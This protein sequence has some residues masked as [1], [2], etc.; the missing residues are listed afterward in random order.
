MT[1][2]L[3]LELWYNALHDPQGWKLTT[4]DPQ[5]MKALLYAARAKT[6]DPSLFTLMI[7]TDPANPTTGLWIIH[8]SSPE[9]QNG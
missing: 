9:A 5:R 3:A 7:R 6:G 1:P 8:T 2:S 4:S